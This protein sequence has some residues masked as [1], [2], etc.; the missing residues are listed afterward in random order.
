MAVAASALSKPA[1]LEPAHLLY[2]KS[3]EMVSIKEQRPATIQIQQM[4]MGEAVLVQ[5]KLDGLELDILLFVRNE[6]TE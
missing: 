3:A 6:E 1:G 5:L 4:V 2:A